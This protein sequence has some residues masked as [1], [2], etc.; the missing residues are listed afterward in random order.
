[1]DNNAVR[2]QVHFSRFLLSLAFGS[3]LGIWRARQKIVRRWRPDPPDANRAELD[4]RASFRLWVTAIY[5]ILG[6]VV[7]GLLWSLASM[8]TQ[9]FD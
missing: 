6:A 7:S 8:L 1:L 4:F 9:L 5:A 2:I 3:A